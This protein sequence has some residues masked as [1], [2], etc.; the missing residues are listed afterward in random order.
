VKSAY[1]LDGLFPVD[2]MPIRRGGRGNSAKADWTSKRNGWA[3]ESDLR[4]T[5]WP[6]FFDIFEEEKDLLGRNKRKKYF[7]SL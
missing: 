1:D 3:I 4:R 6:G 7:W 2:R 5:P